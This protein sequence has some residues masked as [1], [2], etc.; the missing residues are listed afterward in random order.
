MK[1]S[2]HE[3][4][5]AGVLDADM[6]IPADRIPLNLPDQPRLLA[7]L[8]LHVHAEALDDEILVVAS[9]SA[10]MGLVC[11]RCLEAYQSALSAGFEAHAPLAQTEV[12]LLEE[13]RQSLLLA[14][15]AKPLCR[16]E[17]RGLCPRCGANLNRTS[18]GC[19]ESPAE[20]PFAK[21]RNFEV[22]KKQ[23]NG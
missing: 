20:T 2:I 17:C 14:L 3:V 5:D 6:S 16:A 9:L 10:R 12:D 13:A 15:P 7:P 22:L 1:L 18:C 19:G 23:K 21:L 11:A 4:Q 8:D